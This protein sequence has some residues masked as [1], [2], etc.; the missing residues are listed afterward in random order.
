ML[1]I[2]LYCYGVKTA[3]TTPGAEKPTSDRLQNFT[4]ADIIY[5]PSYADSNHPSL[6]PSRADAPFLFYKCLKFEFRA[7]NPTSDRLQHFTFW[8]ISL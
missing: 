2:M 3:G 1:M 4:I 7:R 5:V 6:F 8:Q